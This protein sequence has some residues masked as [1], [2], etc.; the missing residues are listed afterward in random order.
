MSKITKPDN[1]IFIGANLYKDFVQR[2]Y[3]E[4]IYPYIKDATHIEK[5][6][7]FTDDTVDIIVQD[8]TNSKTPTAMF[9][10]D[11][12]Y[13][14]VTKC[15]NSRGYKYIEKD[16]NLIYTIEDS[17]LI[18]KNISLFGN[19]PTPSIS[20]RNVS[21]FKVFG[22][23][24]NIKKLES[25]IEECA[26]VKKVLPTWYNIEIKSAEGEQILIKDAKELNLKI[27]PVR[28]VRAALIKYLSAKGKKIS[29]AESCTGGLLTSKIT[30]IRGASE[31]FEGAMITYS[32]RI[33]HK[34][35]GVKE[36][37]LEKYGAVSKECVKEML[38]GIKEQTNSN[39]SVAI[40]G[41]A[42]PDGGTKDKP[43]GTVYIGIMNEDK[44][45]VKKFNF[46]GDRGF[47]QE[48][49]ARSA[50]E[51]ILYSEPEFFEFF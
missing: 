24:E 12:Y 18:T 7:I 11:T 3:I 13:D 35:L 41:I 21:E 14:R 19:L 36:E 30:A 46:N 33:K 40:S 42:G 9:I 2:A 15:L 31:V 45:K 48:Q 23:Y 28:S 39:I 34:W 49:A 47:I 1:I 43:V 16:D 26:V 37:T 20:D 25:N 27:L 6:P 32:N 8:V 44:I 4:R 22:T 50:I 10:L 5:F 17:L 38:K 29:F 51:M